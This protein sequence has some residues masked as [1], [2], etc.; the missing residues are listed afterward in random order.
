M[1]VRKDSIDAFISP[2]LTVREMMLFSAVVV[3]LQH[4]TVALGEKVAPA[5]P[6]AES[7]AAS[8]ESASGDASESEVAV[9]KAPESTATAADGAVP[10]VSQPK[11]PTS[12]KLNQ[13]L[14]IGSSMGWA[15][16]KTSDAT[17][18]VGGS[19]NLRSS[20]RRSPK[21][22][23]KT[24]ITGRYAAFGGT[25]K[26][27]DD[28]YYNASG[29][30]FLGGMNWIAPWSIGSASHKLGGELGYMLTYVRRQDGSEADAKVKS[31]KGLVGLN[32]QIEWTVL[33]KMKIGPVL[34]VGLG[35]VTSV[36]LGALAMMQF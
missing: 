20:W 6:K 16:V 28:A 7:N 13:R 2:F 9:Q 34:N 14:E 24:F 8:D 12:E 23:G 26:S 11:S 36:E 27:K 5:A 25:L 33:E 32:S 19:A 17:W 29:H 1:K 21:A 22:G 10:A 18:T 35:Q 3:T 31:G 15:S 30:V 4:S